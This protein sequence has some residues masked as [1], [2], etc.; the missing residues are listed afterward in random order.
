MG[1]FQDI[2]AAAELDLAAREVLAGYRLSKLAGEVELGDG[3]QPVDLE[4][5]ASDVEF[6]PEQGEDRAARAE[7]DQIIACGDAGWDLADAREAAA[8][9]EAA[10]REDWAESRYLIA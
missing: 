9:R 2:K 3:F 8:E 5:D 1:L 10:N 4:A 6:E 7:A